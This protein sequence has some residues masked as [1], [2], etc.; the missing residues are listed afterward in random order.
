MNMKFKNFTGFINAYRNELKE[1]DLTEKTRH[2]LLDE[3][4]AGSNLIKN[5]QVVD[6]PYFEVAELVESS[7]LLQVQSIQLNRNNEGSRIIIQGAEH[8]FAEIGG[9]SVFT[10]KLEDKVKDIL[11]SKIIKDFKADGVEVSVDANATIFDKI[12]AIKERFGNKEF[13]IACGLKDYL[14]ITQKTTVCPL[15]VLY[16]PSLN[17]EVFGFT[18]QG[19][20]LNAVFGSVDFHKDIITGVCTVGMSILTLD[21]YARENSIVKITE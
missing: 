19:Y 17:H 16:V 7:G 5:I 20:Y 18:K 10:M 11:E 1:H 13:I 15:K 2:L 12:L 3:V 4:K 9:K 8:D 6:D 14:T 21:S